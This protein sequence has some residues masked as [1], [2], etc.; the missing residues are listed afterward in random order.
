MSW[1]TDVLHYTLDGT[2][3][4]GSN[5]YATESDITQSS[6]SWKVT[7]NTTTNPWRIGG[8][9]ITNTDRPMYSTTAMGSAITKIE[10]E[11]GDITLSSVNSIKLIVASNS[12]FSTVVDEITINP[13][14][15]ATSIAANQTL[16]FQPTSPLTQWATGAYYKIVFNVTVSGSSNK[17]VAFNSAKFYKEGGSSPSI[18]LATYSVNATKDAVSTTSIGVT[19]NNLTDFASEVKF[20]DSDGTTNA[21][22]NHDWVTATINASTKDLDYSIAANTGSPRTAY[23]KVKATYNEG[24]VESDLITVSQASG[25]DA[26]SFSP[27]AG[28]VT[29]GTQIALTQA[30]A[31]SIRYTLDGTEP[32]KT[33]GTVYSGPITI[34]TP[35]TIKAIAIEG[36][37]IS[38]VATAA[39]TISVDA[40]II[41]PGNSSYLPGAPITI[42]AAGNTIYYTLTTDGSTPGNPSSSSTPY[43]TPII[44]GSTT[45]KIKAVAY[46]AYNNK[47]SVASG[48][49][50]IATP[51]SLPFSWTGT[52][53]AGRDNLASKTGVLVNL[54]SDYATSNAPYRLK[55]D[56]V[57]KYVTIYTNERP[58]TVYFT[59]KLLGGKIDTGSKIKVQG[60]VDGSTFTDIEEFTIKGAAN[61]TFEFTTSNA[62]AATHRAVKLVMSE[63]E[64]NVGVGTISIAKYVPGP[65]D[66]VDDG[67]TVT[68][69][70]TDKMD[71]W[72][73]FYD[74]TQ[75]YTLDANT[76][77]YVVRAKSGTEDV[78][79]L[80]KLDV[81]AIPHG[82]PVILK[83]SAA[84]H[85][86]VLTKTT[87]VATLGTNLLD[88]T[89]GVHSYDC[90]RLGY[91]EGTGVAFFRY[92]ATKPAAGIV[93]IDPE[94]VNTGSSAPDFL[95]ISGETTGIDEVRSQKEE[96]RGT[97]FDLQGRKVANPTKGLYIVN[98]KKYV[99][100]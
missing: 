15:P 100:K 96:I 27:T 99:V 39:Y 34:N 12:D 62:F 1:A 24:A 82:A 64:Q 66:P 63:K 93:Y 49:F 90:Y 20:Y 7:G 83:T 87:G 17:Y 41:T 86:M 95:S 76:K 19:Y 57:D 60:S 21:T 45:T 29:A 74:A 53:D 59:V 30:S 16:T 69:T 6:I 13:V 11:I 79:E 31:T 9:N 94:N 18:S 25:I 84:D 67:S 65:S 92:A 48:T 61:K 26:P 56:A 98:G 46:D 40:P 85:K 38:D 88:V 3:T 33:T 81:T 32:T 36:E 5:G 8:N 14:S 43:T 47:S 55:F 97:F 89:D 50:T 91:K 54:G 78:V 28:A 51:A 22:Y 44:L 77:A 72:R 23:F 75:D 70:T 58:G 4:G 10:L 73:S 52:S 80:T 35:T 37:E 2:T 71:G 68:L 42:S